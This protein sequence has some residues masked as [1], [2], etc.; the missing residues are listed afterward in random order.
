ML[1]KFA[2]Q[3]MKLG[4]ILVHQVMTTLPRKFGDE[5]I[6]GGHEF[7]RDRKGLGEL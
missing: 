7:R 2:S 6:Y 1:S 3:F 5:G 4:A